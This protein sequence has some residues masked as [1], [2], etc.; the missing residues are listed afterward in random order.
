MGIEIERKFIFVGTLPKEYDESLMI[1]QF[2]VSESTDSEVRVRI[3]NDAATLTIKSKEPGSRRT[4]FEYDLPISDAIDLQALFGENAIEK[5]RYVVAFGNL[6]W[7]IDVFQGRL[8]GLILAEVELK[9]GH[10]EKIELPSWLGSEVTEDLRFRNVE[11]A[12]IQS[13]DQM[14]S[15]VNSVL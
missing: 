15:L 5:T 7:E 1:T 12:K 6:S 4:E 2:Y 9:E 14:R 11:L 3:E 13:P 8:S 10:D